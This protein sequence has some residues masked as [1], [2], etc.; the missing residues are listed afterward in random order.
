MTSITINDIEDD[1]YLRFERQFLSNLIDE[2]NVKI[3][4]MSSFLSTPDSNII[5]MKRTGIIRCSHLRKLIPLTNIEL[6]YKNLKAMKVGGRGI[7]V[8]V[9]LPIEYS[10]EL[11]ALVGHVMGDG[12]IN[13]YGSFEYANKD[14][15]LINKVKDHTYDV[16][17]CRIY[18]EIQVKKPRGIVFKIMYPSLIGRILKIAGA[19]QGKKVTQV[20][21]VPD[22]IKR[23]NPKTKSEFLKALFDDDGSVEI[24]NMLTFTNSKRKKL[25]KYHEIYIN[26]ICNLLQEFGINTQIRFRDQDDNFKA[27]IRITNLRNLEKFEENIGFTQK[28]RRSRLKYILLNPTRKYNKS[29]EGMKIIYNILEKSHRALTTEELSSEISR[30]LSMTRN[31]LFRLEK[32]GKIERVFPQRHKVKTL[33]KCKNKEYEIPLTES[34]N[35]IPEI[36]SD[37]SKTSNLIS[38]ILNKDRTLVIKNLHKL[39]KQNKVKIIKRDSQGFWW[40]LV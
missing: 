36:L 34:L 23:S 8:P 11:A 16:F 30:N 3:G 31:Y 14:Y 1:F 2:G 40:G 26:S 15:I 19:P 4:N 12:T 10:T 9:R 13:S 35:S 17:K 20:F 24:G 25:I 22:W 32:S 29:G 39:K 33:W 28:R 18:R 7:E 6:I 27:D 21:D 38:E 37:G 5:R